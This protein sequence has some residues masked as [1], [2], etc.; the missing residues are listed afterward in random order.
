MNTPASPS[1]PPPADGST[2]P[3]DPRA[4]CTPGDGQCLQEKHLGNMSADDVSRCL[5]IGKRLPSLTWW[6]SRHEGLGCSPRE[7]VDAGRISDVEALLPK[8]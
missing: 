8:G 3:T 7:A 6:Y 4:A 1:T 5:E 2:A